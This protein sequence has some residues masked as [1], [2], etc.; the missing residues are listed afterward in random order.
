MCNC[1]MPKSWI[2][3]SYCKISLN[4]KLRKIKHK[5]KEMYGSTRVSALGIETIADSNI[6]LIVI[7]HD[8][9]IDEEETK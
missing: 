2:Y 3:I 7:I 4:F 1:R 6:P 5:T 8:T 9:K